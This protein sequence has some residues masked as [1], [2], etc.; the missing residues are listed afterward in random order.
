MVFVQLVEKSYFEV[1]NLRVISG[2]WVIYRQK[3]T[4]GDL[5]DQKNYY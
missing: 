4:S 1:K 3:L 2:I 5:T